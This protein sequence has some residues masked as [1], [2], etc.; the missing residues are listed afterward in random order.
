MLKAMKALY[1]LYTKYANVL[2]E[3]RTLIEKSK[4]LNLKPNCIYSMQ[5]FEEHYYR[6]TEEQNS[7]G[8]KLLVKKDALLDSL[9]PKERSY[10]NSANDINF[11]I[12][13]VNL[14]FVYIVVVWILFLN[15]YIIQNP[16]FFVYNVIMLSIVY[17]IVFWANF[18]VKL[19]MSSTI[20]A[21]NSFGKCNVFEK[22]AQ[23][24]VI[25]YDNKLNNSN[26]VCN[27]RSRYDK[28]VYSNRSRMHGIR[29]RDRELSRIPK[30]RIKLILKKSGKVRRLL[31]T[32]IRK[33]IPKSSRIHLFTNKAREKNICTWNQMS[34]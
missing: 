30:K 12:R 21:V 24:S 32:Y 26:T 5:S 20:A 29:V 34:E 10:D 17:A 6:G 15:K 16:V 23:L 9:D 11:T 28:F 18:Y 4:I 3:K 13:K 33:S 19:L 2:V 14:M 22:A 27:C 7:Y 1:A 31:R 8:C 25:V